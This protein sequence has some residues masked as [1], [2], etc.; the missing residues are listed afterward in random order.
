[1]PDIFRSVGDA[2]DT[3]TTRIMIPYGET[4]AFQTDENGALLSPRLSDINDGLTQTL[5]LIEVGSDRSV[6]WSKPDDVN[7]DPADPLDTLGNIESATFRATTF[8]PSTENLHHLPSNIQADAF[9]AF[10][11]RFGSH[12]SASVSNVFEYTPFDSFVRQQVPQLDPPKSGE[13]YDRLKSLY[14]GL[15]NHHSVYKQL[16]VPSES[17]YFQGD[18][19]DPIQT[20]KPNLS[21]RVHLLPFLGNLPLYRQLH[22]DE[23]WDSPHNLSLVPL[24]PDVFRSIG[25]D[26]KSTTTRMQMFSQR[27]HPDVPGTCRA[28]GPIGCELGPGRLFRDM[29][30]G[31]SN[32]LLLAETGPDVAV[33]W[34][35]PVDMFYEI[36]DPAAPWDFTKNGYSELGDVAEGF[37]GLM[38]DGR[39]RFL[40]DLNPEHL[41]R[42]IT[43]ASK[44]IPESPDWVVT[45]TKH[46]IVESEF[47]TLNVATETAWPT[48]PVTLDV[49]LSDPGLIESSTASLTFGGEN[50]LPVQSVQIRGIDNGQI[51]GPRTVTV[52]VGDE[53]IELTLI[54]KIDRPVM[55]SVQVESVQINSGS[56][57]RSNVAS[58]EVAFD[59]MVDLSELPNAFFVEDAESGLSVE[60]VHVTASHVSNKTVAHLTFSGNGTLERPSMGDSVLV[61]GNFRL[62]I[63]ADHVRMLGTNITVDGDGNGIAGGDHTFGDQFDDAL[64][65]L[66]GDSDGDG[67]IGLADFSGFRNS[68]GQSFGNAGF[69]DSFD[70]D[71]DGLVTLIDFGAF[72]QKFGTSRSPL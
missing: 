46:V 59:Q 45:P 49:V 70:S 54:D 68:F 24:M 26:P 30:D 28:A 12:P 37:F 35:E 6:I 48:D 71:G 39:V 34:T 64:F 41:S 7:Y 40:D 32:T 13:M 57:Q 56:Q 3:N 23:P 25:D 52:S 10:V 29:I 60:H 67:H 53:T 1:M 61:D 63:D 36:P 9:A 43:R 51:D 62:K 58:I 14:L 47:I 69:N 5:A 19:N 2:K 4:A 22:L 66:F 20:R 27:D 31:T 65:A 50:H 33:T 17:S 11:S 16:P 18:P 42:L 38:G 72:R 55:E 44:D 21:W 15:F 8:E